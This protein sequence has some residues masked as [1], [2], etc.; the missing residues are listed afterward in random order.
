[1]KGFFLQ[2]SLFSS[3]EGFFIATNVNIEINITKATIVSSY[4]L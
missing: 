1:M 2:F 3:N 4:T